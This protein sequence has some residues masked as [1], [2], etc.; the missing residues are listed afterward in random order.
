MDDSEVCVSTRTPTCPPGTSSHA[1]EEGVQDTHVQPP[2]C[3][4]IENQPH[5]AVQSG[6]TASF[7]ASVASPLPPPKPTA[8]TPSVDLKKA[9]DMR[10]GIQRARGPA[11]TR[12]LGQPAVAC[13][14]LLDTPWGTRGVGS[15]GWHCRGCVHS[16]CPHPHPGAA[17]RVRTHSG[18]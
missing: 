2:L 9:R 7:L 13:P 10:W 12:G 17:C 8:S 16:G 18:L 6:P 4:G 11:L 5:P 3:S 1:C 15:E 14:E